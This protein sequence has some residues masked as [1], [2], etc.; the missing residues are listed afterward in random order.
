MSGE[1][2]AACWFGGLGILGFAV[3]FYERYRTKK[4]I[5]QSLHRD[6]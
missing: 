1:L 3:Y 5:G 2:I 4:L 6:L